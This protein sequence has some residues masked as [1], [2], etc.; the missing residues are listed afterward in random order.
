MPNRRLRLPPPD[1]LQ[2]F[3]VA[4][5]LLSFTET[6]Q[7]CFLT[8]S[9][10]SRRIKALEDDLGVLLFRR[11]H[12]SLVLTPEGRQLARACHEAFGR[13]RDAVASIQAGRA[14]QV[15]TVTTTPGLAALWLIPRLSHF[16]A[17]HP[18]VDVRI[19]A[20]LLRRDLE[21]DGIDVSV[22]YDDVNHG[23]GRK[24]FDEEVLPVC[25][26]SLLGPGRP[27]LRRPTDLAHHTLLQLEPGPS[28]VNLLPEWTPWLT[29]MNLPDLTGRA[30][31]TFSNYDAVIAAA[32]HGQGVALGRRPLVDAL[33]AEGRLVA[34]LRAGVVSARAY[35]VRLS[36]QARERPM[37]Q[38]FA[39]WLLREAAAEPRGSA[40]G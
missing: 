4:A 1:L 33:I 19:D 3:E 35:Y 18:E 17:D 24:L 27:R 38:E 21:A 20:T 10:V 28:S 16:T 9:A 34:P 7:E 31:L 13:L 26:P 6:A 23:V 36:E 15:L 32:V 40:G 29:A 12:R 14:R 30:T 11:A 25:S 2:T 39:D 8:Q 5:R 22:R 37:A